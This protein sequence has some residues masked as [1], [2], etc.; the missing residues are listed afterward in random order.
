MLLALSPYLPHP[1]LTSI[2]FQIKTIWLYGEMRG[3]SSLMWLSLVATVSEKARGKSIFLTAGLLRVARSKRVGEVPKLRMSSQTRFK[4]MTARTEMK[5][6]L[7]SLWISSLVILIF[8]GATLLRRSSATALKKLKPPPPPP[9]L[10]APRC[11]WLLLLLL[12]LLPKPREFRKLGFVCSFAL[13]T[14]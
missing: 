3:K 1:L 10:L 6:F 14:L 8:A 9:L 11:Y 7:K 12:L 5:L 2:L 4:R 13:L